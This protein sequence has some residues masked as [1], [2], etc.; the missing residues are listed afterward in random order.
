MS[1]SPFH[2]GELAVQTRLG[3][4]E[5][6]DAIGRRV[7]RDHMPDQHREFFATL[8]TLL[9]G[10]LDARR[11]PWASLLVG[12]PGFI[13]TPDARTL[14]VAA[15]PGFGDPLRDHL[16][17]GAALGL[18]GIEPH[19]RRRNRVNGT[20]TTVR[21]GGFTLRVDQSFGNCPKYIQ[22][23]EPRWVA[24]PAT[25]GDERPVHREG[26]TLG[27]AACELIVRAD[28]FFIAS[29]AASTAGGRAGGVDVSHRGGRRGFV[30][31][32][33]EHGRS[34][35]TVPDFTGNFLFNTLGNVAANPVA[36][37]LFADPDRGDLLQLTGS[38]AVVWEGPE[39]A[40][41]A[42]AERL[43]RVTVEEGRWM[44]QAVPLRWTAPRLSPQ[45]A[46]TGAWPD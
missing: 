40:V 24:E 44:P 10:S 38:A 17:P 43:L 27:E 1:N 21:D 31:V 8:P 5:Q 32:R 34:V 20:L 7:I 6:I 13:H 11:R 36:G 39:V 9:V 33:A 28:T 41:F 30:R 26:P 16:V 15:P 14:A 29:A 2:P 4:R 22:A 46:N 23:R 19:T 3:V 12:R 18:L 25:F 37:L 42:G 35:L 45:L